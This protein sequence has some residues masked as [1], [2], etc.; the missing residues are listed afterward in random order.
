M[1]QRSDCG[2]ATPSLTWCPVFLLEVVSITSLSLLSDISSKVPHFDSWES[3]TSQ[4][5]GAFWTVP[6]TS[7]FLRLPVSILSVGPRSFSPFPSPN[8]RSASPLLLTPHP[9]HFP[10]AL[11]IAFFSLP[12]RAEVSS[13]GHF[14]LL[15]L[16]SLL[17]SVDLYLRYSVPFLF[18]G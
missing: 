11:V 5:L 15:S 3:L 18:F 14:S 12:S 2:M 9:I 16:L 6:P 4:V 1:G 10:S 8:T 7:Y 13:L 17:S